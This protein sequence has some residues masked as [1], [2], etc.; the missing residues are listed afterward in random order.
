M[1]MTS[2]LW[3]PLLALSTAAHG[4]DRVDLSLPAQPMFTGAGAFGD[5][6]YA[7]PRITAPAD[8]RA[9]H[10]LALRGGCPSAPD[11]SERT[12]TGSVS[13]GVG[14]SSRGG[15]SHWN[16]ADIS[17]CKETVGD[18]GRPGTMQL[19]LRVA[20][21]DGPGYPG[22]YGVGLGPYD[23]PGGFGAGSYFDG[24]GPGWRDLHEPGLRVRTESWTDGRQPWR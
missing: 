1:R 18:S 5:G 19:N 10:P 8:R 22:Y 13:T 21:Y 20:Q 4:E 7:G 15:N 6:E 17:L 2:L 23:G 16:A 9:H 24:F 11:G 12:V 3:I 14:Y